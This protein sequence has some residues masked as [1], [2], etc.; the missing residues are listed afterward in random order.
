[1]VAAMQVSG[2]SCMLFVRRFFLFILLIAAF[3]TTGHALPLAWDGLFTTVPKLNP[4]WS[5]VGSC[6]AAAALILRHSATFR[7]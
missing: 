1:M 3:A 6:L 2:L 5:A 4:A 7:K